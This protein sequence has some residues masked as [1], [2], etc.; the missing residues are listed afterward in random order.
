MAH[1]YQTP[2]EGQSIA[3]EKG[4]KGKA[5]VYRHPETGAEAICQYDP[6]FGNAQANAFEKIGFKW[7]RDVKEGEVKTVEL[8]ATDVNRTESD[9]MKGLTARMNAM[10]GVT[11]QNKVL[12]EANAKLREELAARGPDATDVSGAHARSNA[13]DQ[14]NLRPEIET[15]IELTDEGDVVVTDSAN[16]PVNDDDDDEDESVSEKPLK[17]LNRAELNAKAEE[18]GIRDAS[19]E[20]KYKTKG[21]LLAAIEA[22]DQESETE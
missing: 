5:G 15:P 9:T 3:S 18:K 22:K 11:E 12:E 19:D 14:T 6:L 10:E 20:E 8:T 2:V 7:M 4:G 21:D 17:A 16:G 1:K 13:V